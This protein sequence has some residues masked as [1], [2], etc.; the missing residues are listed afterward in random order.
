MNVV[1]SY[2]T[3]SD[4][5]E[6]CNPSAMPTYANV[7]KKFLF[8][9]AAWVFF[10]AGTPPEDVEWYVPVLAAIAMGVFTPIFLRSDKEPDP[11]DLGMAFILIFTSAYVF[12]AFCQLFFW[13][14]KWGP[15]D[16]RAKAYAVTAWASDLLT[17]LVGWALALRCT[18]VLEWGGHVLY[19]FSIPVSYFL[20]YILTKKLSPEVDLRRT[21]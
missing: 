7:R 8:T 6:K 14:P 18:K 2:G 21:D 13:V 19:D 4:N 20:T 17:T 16:K 5:A 1:L 11:N 12:S 10:W 3:I 9:V 15:D